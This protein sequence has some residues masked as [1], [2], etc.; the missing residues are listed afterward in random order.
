M[1]KLKSSLNIMII[2]FLSFFLFIFAAT[3]I[4]EI[5]SALSYS[6]T[7]STSTLS[8]YIED[9]EYYRLVDRV[10]DIGVD[11]RTSEEYQS[12]FALGKYYEMAT[13]YKATIDNPEQSALYLEK[14]EYYYELSGNLQLCISDIHQQLDINPIY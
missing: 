12:Y 1:N 10:N 4:T 3:F 14:L 6:Y 11:K 7:P 9:Q 8:W 5:I 2:I 13:L